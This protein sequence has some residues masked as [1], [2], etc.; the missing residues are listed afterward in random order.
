MLAEG[1]RGP[2]AIHVNTGYTGV[3]AILAAGATDMITIRGHIGLAII[4]GKP[5]VLEFELLLVLK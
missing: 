1:N 2:G 4:D 3:E 5:A